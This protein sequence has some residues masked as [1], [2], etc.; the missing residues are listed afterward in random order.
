MINDMTESQL[1]EWHILCTACSDNAC[2][3]NGMQSTVS[4]PATAGAVYH[5]RI[6][7][8]LQSGEGTVVLDCEP[9][10]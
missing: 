3:E 5:V 6:G 2:G 7:G 1:S 10:P 9:A 8:R 4:F